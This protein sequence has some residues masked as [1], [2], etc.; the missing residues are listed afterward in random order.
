[1]HGLYPVKHKNMS[2]QKH[3]SSDTAG[4]SDCVAKTKS[5][6]RRCWVK[7]AEV[8]E[9][10]VLLRG[11]ME[12]DL[13]TSDL[14]YFLLNQQECRKSVKK[15][16][17]SKAGG[18]DKLDCVRVLMKAKIS[19]NIQL[20]VELRRKRERLRGVLETKMGG[21]NVRCL[22]NYIDKVKKSVAVIRESVRKKNFIKLQHLSKKHRD[23]KKSILPEQLKRYTGTAIFQEEC[24]MAAERLNGP[25]VVEDMDGEA[26]D[27]GED[28]IALLSKGPKFSVYKRCD[29]ES[30]LESMEAAF[31]KHCWEMR[32]QGEDELPDGTPLTEEE[33][34]E[35]DR[36]AE[37][38]RDMDAES[39][40]IFTN[41]DRVFD[42]SRQR[43]TDVKNNTRV[44]LPRPMSALEE[45]KL[46]VLR[47]EWNALFDRYLAEECGEGGEQTSNLTAQ[48]RR[49][50]KSLKQRVKDGEIVVLQTDKSGR[51]AVMSMKTYITAGEKH[52]AK[53]S[54]VGWEEVKENQSQ[55]NGH[56]SMWLKV[57]RVGQKWNHAERIRETMLNNSMAVCPL[58][59]LFKDHKGWSWRMGE[60][61]PS[62]PV[63]SGA[64]G[65]NLHLSELLSQVMEPIANNWVGGLETISCE[66]MLSRF[67]ALNIKNKGWKPARREGKL[68]SEF[69]VEGGLLQTPVNVTSDADMNTSTNSG[70]KGR[71]EVQSGFVNL[72]MED[73]TAGEEF[74]CPGQEFH[75]SNIDGI[76]PGV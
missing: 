20:E 52:T 70:R 34:R 49:G 23:K 66:D 43:A 11:L 30:F 40:M 36:L 6:L 29:R 57:F 38:E 59:L 37:I 73:G 1:M 24:L 13:G 41:R 17:G 21:R 54:E 25:V 39:R 72:D 33:E 26:V 27:L 12:S 51:F 61:P 55:L 28:E 16:K 69:L 31:I 18:K 35:R 32:Q 7:C 76:P 44:I 10:T 14:E 42:W 22:R 48:E 63:A 65:M 56:V 9:G 47:L 15:G 74:A 2:N 67:D 45:S 4:P 62:R 5:K 19:D 58:Y 8:E 68:T 3:N 50:L 46:A 75:D 53:D 64:V 71:E 60:A